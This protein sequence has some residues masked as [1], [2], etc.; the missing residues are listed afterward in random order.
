VTS[1]KATCVESRGKG[2]NGRPVSPRLV[3]RQSPSDKTS[4]APK[5]APSGQRYARS[6]GADTKPAAVGARRRLP[7]SVQ[8]QGPRRVRARCA[9]E[10]DFPELFAHS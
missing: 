1:V 7:S 4:S 6:F 5:C 9:A 2:Q 3:S 8:R 10:R